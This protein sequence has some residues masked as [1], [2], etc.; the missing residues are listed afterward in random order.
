[1]TARGR[2]A[3]VLAL[4][5]AIG[6][7][8]AGEANPPA[9]KEPP[10]KGPAA[11]PADPK[12]PEEATPA[13]PAD[14]EK[15]A[16][17]ARAE[18]L[19]KLYENAEALYNQ[20]RYRDAQKLYAQI[21]LDEPG[22]R[23]VAS[24]LESIRKRLAEEDR[25][26]RE[27]QLERLLEV[28]DAHHATGN[29]EAA[30]KACEAVLAIEPT[31]KRARQRF[32]ECAAELDLRRRVASIIA[33]PDVRPADTELLAQAKTALAEGQPA[34]AAPKDAAPVIRSPKDLP[35]AQPPA[36][37]PA[38]AA[39]KAETA[40]RPAP[41]AHGNNQDND[42]EG[43]RLIKD[44][45]DLVESANGAQEPKPLLR[46]A[47]DTLAPIAV[48]S[49]HSERSKETAA[50]LRRS[51]SRRLAQDGRALTADEAQRARLYKRYLEA[52][53][54]FRKKHYQ[55]CVDATTE[56]LDEDRS[57]TLARQLNQEARIKVHEDEMEEKDIQ[58][59][60]AFDQRMTEIEDMS[61]PRGMP[62]SVPRSP[63][64]LTRP[65]YEIASP[66]L[67]EKLNQKLTV[68]LIA[69]DL[70]YLLD[71]L[72]RSTGVNI[73]YNPDAVQGKTITL[74]VANFPLRQLLDYIAENHGLEFVTTRD[75]V[76]IT[77][78]DQ[79]RLESFIIPLLYGL[80]D[81]GEAPPSAA[82][83]AQ[84]VAATT[85]TP[86]TTSDIEKLLTVLPQLIKWPQGSFFYLDR[87]MNLIYVRTTR[88]AY[89]EVVRMLDPIDQ[90]PP[91]V[92]IKTL[93]IQL[94]ADDFESAGVDLTFSTVCSEKLYP[95]L[96][97]DA[98]T[99]SWVETLDPTTTGLSL[100]VKGGTSTEASSSFGA[101]TYGEEATN[102]QI[103]FSG[104]FNKAQF[105]LTLDALQRTGRARTLNA[106][107]V[108]CVNN[109]TATISITKTLIYI[110]DYQVDRADISGTSY[111]NPYYQQQQV[112]GQTTGYIPP[113]SSEPVITPVFAEDEYTGFTLD[114][115]P[116][117]GKDTRYISLTLNPR[118]RQ[119]VP[120]RLKFDLYLPATGG[121]AVG[122]T[123][124]TTGLQKVQVERPIVQ[125]QAL[126]T[127]LFVADGSIV[128]LGGL[129]QQEKSEVRSK[130]PILGDIP[131][132]GYLFSKTSYRDKKKNLL[133]F[134]QAE[135][136]TP[137]GARYADSGRIDEARATETP[138][139][140]DGEVAPPVVRREPRP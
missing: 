101:D 76:L 25:K 3:V 93:F 8:S 105:E 5:L 134:V 42:P 78:P 36:P 45:W 38:P 52:E 14:A 71:L 55:D 114:V 50:L 34:P 33:E 22:Y 108:I 19:A 103:K 75:G 129:I 131:I 24:R 116:S 20:G 66:E 15:A 74:H 96:T 132:I 102:P 18:R 68:N 43:R 130:I 86:P 126:S 30:A 16:E 140:P 11:T 40:P 48:T 17:A 27:A 133:I 117:V 57:F 61:V 46:K 21:A 54:L 97:W 12:P 67:E 77:T 139:R 113:L 90:L 98:T 32:S 94:E 49:K 26:A 58:H 64:E 138:A 115:I 13:K 120:P 44:A 123:P 128:G 92:L 107:N 60:V 100:P 137:T 47:L 125:E 124:T 89:H 53:E 80:M 72:F 83:A 118:I 29:F 88:D 37:K 106:P 87:K 112:P 4:A 35:P 6:S 81:V 56:I 99:S 82:V 39:P 62:P 110:E 111:G 85:L 122:G 136:I 63:I 79:P 10:K 28:A 1:M 23:R 69:A 135:L 127:K 84:N 119:E 31:N 7:S 70:D 51:I 9:P 73:I 41:P 59:R 2:L 95:R 109:C 65:T 121:S 91:M 104:V